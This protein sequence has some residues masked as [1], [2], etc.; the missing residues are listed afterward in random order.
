MHKLDFTDF[1]EQLYKQCDDSEKLKQN[2]P[3]YEWIE[4]HTETLVKYKGKTIAI[5]A[6]YGIVAHGDTLGEVARIVHE[7]N[8][9]GK[10]LYTTVPD[11]PFAGGFATNLPEL[12][13][14]C[15]APINHKVN[16]CKYCEVEY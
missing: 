13:D 2:N 3:E 11:L 15:G 14:Y 6:K 16:Q 10:V 5:S 1:W 4:Q 9:T 12:C 8:L 7:K